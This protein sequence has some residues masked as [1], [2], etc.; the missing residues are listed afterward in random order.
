MFG[1]NG[2]FAFCF[3]ASKALRAAFTF[4]LV[5]IGFDGFA[6]ELGAARGAYGPLPNVVQLGD[7]RLGFIHTGS[8]PSQPLFTEVNNSLSQ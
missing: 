6:F 8:S 1:D 3:F 5:C 2:R 4:P 7:R